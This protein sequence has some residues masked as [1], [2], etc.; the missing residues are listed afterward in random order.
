[1][2]L[3]ASKFLVISIPWSWR[4]TRKLLVL[5]FFP[6]LIAILA[7]DCRAGGQAPGGPTGRMVRASGPIRVDGLL[8]E[9][10]WAAAPVLGEVRQREPNPGQPATER[11][12]VKLLRDDQNFYIGVYCFDSAPSRIIGTRM[13]RD[14]DLGDDDRIEVLIDP[15]LDKRNAFYFST[16]P[17]GALVDGLIIENGSLNRDWDAIWV[18]RARA[19][20]DGWTAEFAIPFGSLSFRAGQRVWGFNLSRTIKRKFEEDRL[21][22]PRLETRFQQ[23]SEAGEIGGLEDITQG[24]GLDVRPFLAG[25][26]LREAQGPN[27]VFTGK[28]GLDVF[29]NLTPNLKLTTTVNTDFGET[30]VDARQINLTRF[31]LFLPEKRSFF[32]ENVGVFNF[33]N[34]GT[35]GG[36][37]LR[38]LPFFS[39]RIG[40][41]G[42]QEVPIQ[43]GSKLTGKV[44]NTNIG[45]LAV[46][47]RQAGTI[48]PKTFFVGRAKQ[49]IFEQSYFGG[50]YVEGNPAEQL[51]SRTYGGDLHLGT[52]HF[53]GRDR[54]FTLDAFALQSSNEGVSGQDMAYGVTAEYPN[55]V[56]RVLFRWVDAQKNFSP[57]LGFSSR[58]NV[59]YLEPRFEFNP[60]PR[61]F[62]GIRQMFHEAFLNYYSR[63]D[64]GEVES[65]RFQTSPINWR[66]N[67]GDEVELNYAPQFERLF[68]PFE[69]ASGVVLPTGGYRFDRWRVRLLAASKRA[70]SGQ[71][72]TWFGEYY[73][74]HANE[75]NVT[76]NYKWAPRL[77]TSFQGEQTF[78]RLP[79]GNFVARIFTARVNYSLTPFV[80]FSNLIQYDNESRNLGWQSRFRWIVK[81]GNDLFLVFN[82]GWL[83]KLGGG[84]AYDVA[85]TKLAAKVQ[86]TFRF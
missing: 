21:F 60:R 49:N 79:E 29:Y 46:R 43:V 52:S 76:V 6:A 5:V 28:P 59:R 33:S 14:S 67:S 3:Y 30:E 58:E 39:R 19:A 34:I 75:V 50:I 42:N 1:L 83:Q 15:Y 65:W 63:L 77:Q 8:D 55:D 24:H 45:I 27:N 38:I 51:S 86:Y 72:E 2:P 70:L 17:L 53:L 13:A 11:T 26:W 18:V 31:P 36:G 81:P 71:V 64:T 10:D 32:L 84:F 74:G 37:A 4:G 56:V 68:E 40:L 61:G 23:V 41:V 73:S 35:A 20:E 9:A 12:E 80:T 7:V 62:L 54:T 85:D 25:R 22:S 44:A 57:A 66:F 78:A 48:P 47:T 82:Q 16:N 69:I